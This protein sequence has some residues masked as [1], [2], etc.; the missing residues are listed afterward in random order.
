[1]MTKFTRITVVILDLILAKSDRL[2]LRVLKA[3]I[4]VLEGTFTK[5]MIEPY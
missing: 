5:I 3:H 2:D 1:M 4:K